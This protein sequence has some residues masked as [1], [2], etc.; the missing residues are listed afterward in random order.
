M[1]KAATGELIAASMIR[2]LAQLAAAMPTTG[3]FNGFLPIEPWKRA[4]PKL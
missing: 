4:L 3:A 2:R 1:Y